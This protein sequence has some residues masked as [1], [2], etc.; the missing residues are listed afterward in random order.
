M[1]RLLKRRLILPPPSAR[2]GNTILIKREDMQPVFSFK[3]RGA[4]NKL[5]RLSRSGS[6]GALS[7][8]RRV[9]MHKAWPYRRRRLV[10]GR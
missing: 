5:A 4:Y 2:T 9:I 3:L 8:H 10:A 7:V 1:M 6:N